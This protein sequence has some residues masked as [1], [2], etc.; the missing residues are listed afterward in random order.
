VAQCRDGA[1]TPFLELTLQQSVDMMA[2]NLSGVMLCCQGAARA[3]LNNPGADRSIL[4]TSSVRALRASTGRV[5][6]SVGK[7]AVSQLV[8][9]VAAELAPARHPRQTAV[10]CWG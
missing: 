2:P 8:R 1:T 6:Y 3:M 5:A 9:M 10:K 7:A 4:A